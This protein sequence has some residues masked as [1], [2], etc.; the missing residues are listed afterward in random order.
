MTDAR[1]ALEQELRH[2]EKEFAVLVTCKLG[3][4]VVM[5]H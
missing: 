1:N 4:W 5:G 2:N 3:F